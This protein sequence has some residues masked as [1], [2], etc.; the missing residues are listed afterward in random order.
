MKKLL[1]FMLLLICS[2]STIDKNKI[3]E[4]NIA[5]KKMY[6]TEESLNWLVY[7]KI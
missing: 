7:M 2:C 6:W 4:N 1:F 5:D 3:I